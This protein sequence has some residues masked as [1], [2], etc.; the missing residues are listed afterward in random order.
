MSTTLGY[1]HSNILPWTFVP[2]EERRFRRVIQIA[3]V[4]YF[5][6]VIAASVI[7]VPKP[8]RSAAQPLP[9]QLAKLIL[10]REKPKPKPPEI[11]EEKKPEQKKEAD[12]PKPEE[13]KKPEKKVEE[14]KPEPVKED[15]P[16]PPPKVD[17]EAARKKA[18]KSGLLALSDD[19]A[20]L[21]EAPTVNLNTSIGVIKNT[22]PAKES[23]SAPQV[24]TQTRGGSGGVDTRALTS[25]IASRRIA[26][27]GGDLQ[28][29]ATE[30][31]DSPVEAQ[32][33]LESKSPNKTNRVLPRSEEEINLIMQRYKGAI[34]QMYQRA[35][36]TD[37]TLKGNVV[38][39]I[40]IEPSGAVSACKVV[41]SE[42]DAPDLLG[43]V[44][45]RIKTINFG[46]KDVPAMTIS[47]P[48]VFVPTD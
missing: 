26:G 13:K 23:T 37:P 36:R 39:E 42:M 27:G 35:R 12:K 20:D 18:A 22:A 21:R 41:S 19:L 14:K 45:A 33:K 5:V 40:T 17:I 2:D 3:L 7:T 28:T 32:A 15:V 44:I 43:K 10:E 31:V 6:V 4:F 25:G 16:P 38:F 9:P 48:F 24:L 46:V 30:Q 29:R 8:E 11:I 34:T 1:Y 47:Y